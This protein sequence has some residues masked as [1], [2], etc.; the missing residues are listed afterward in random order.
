M[1][2][3]APEEFICPICKEWTDE[4]DPCC[5]RGPA[6]MDAEYD[7]LKEIWDEKGSAHE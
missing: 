1:L 6:D 4:D 2:N 7:R 3:L 5:G